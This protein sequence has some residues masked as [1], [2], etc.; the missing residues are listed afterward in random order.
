MAVAPVKNVEQVINYAVTQIS[1]DKI[2]MGIPNYGYDWVV[3]YKR[4]ITKAESIGNDFAPVLAFNNNAEIKY[5]SNAQSPYFMY[6]DKNGKHHVVWFEDVRSI[7]EKYKVMDKNNLLGT[8]YWNI[9]RSF[10]P[11]WSYVNAKYDINKIVK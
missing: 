4:G 5:D 2:F 11:N 8:G 3:P 10:V 9:M 6:R 1:P 7:R